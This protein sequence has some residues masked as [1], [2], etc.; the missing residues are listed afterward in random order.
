MLSFVAN[1][2]CSLR[3]GD[4]CSDP[5]G[6]STFTSSNVTTEAIPMEPLSSVSTTHHA[7]SENSVPVPQRSLEFLDEGLAR[8]QVHGKK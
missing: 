5:N 1:S 3:G 2:T 8:M 7:N 4:H 6:P